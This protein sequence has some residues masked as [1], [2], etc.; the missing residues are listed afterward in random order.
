MTLRLVVPVTDTTLGACSWQS[1]D[2]EGQK[3]TRVAPVTRWLPVRIPENGWLAS[4]VSGV[5]VAPVSVGRGV[6]ESSCTAKGVERPEAPTAVSTITCQEPLARRIPLR[7][8]DV[9]SGTTTSLDGWSEQ[10]LDPLLQK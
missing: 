7:R 3:K 9:A 8:I 10:R 5:Q 4:G 6:G 1:V 2:P